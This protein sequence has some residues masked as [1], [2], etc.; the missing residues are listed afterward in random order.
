MKKLEQ[1]LEAS[2]QVRAEQ[3]ESKNTAERVGGVLCDLTDFLQNKT[4][5]TGIN[6]RTNANGVTIEV[7]AQTGDGQEASTALVFPKAS[8]TQA[9]I[10]T[11]ELLRTLRAGI[12][13]NSSSIQNLDTVLQ[14]CVS[15]IS[16]A[17]ASI[18]ENS[19]NIKDLLEASKLHDTRLANHGE[20][21]ENNQALLRQHRTDIAEAKAA[22][23]AAQESIQ[24]NANEIASAQTAISAAQASIQENR[25][26]IGTLHTASEVHDTRLAQ[27]GTAIENA[28]TSIRTNRTDIADAK[29]AI[30]AAQES[31]KGNANDI[32]DAKAAISA[33][34]ESIQENRDRIGTLHTAS[35]I[36]D[37]RLGNHGTAIEDAQKSILKHTNDIK[38]VKSKLDEYPSQFILD[39]GTV[40]SQEEGESR[41]ASSDVAGNRNISFIRFQTQGV[42]NLKTT[43]ILQYPNG[44]NYTAQ[45]K[46]VDKAQW[47][48][49]VTGATGVKGAAT[50]ATQWERT[51]PHYLG[52][53]AA[54]RKIQFKDYTQTVSR[55]VQLPLATASTAGLLSEADYQKIQWL[56]SERDRLSNAINDI[57]TRLRALENK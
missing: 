18:N 6:V 9:G 19:D 22:I 16:A 49:N 7:R 15:K 14:D 53:D 10:I 37:I 21:I 8:E 26:R 31:I 30:S 41:A 43:L 39:L 13:G 28:Q 29:A 51:A 35:E 2:A 50:T 25:Y 42:S 1:I 12:N 38:E 34:Q 23:S 40:S 11:S 48:R 20:A 57:D 45:I 17:Q 32:S 46:Y 33:A 56:I 27:H 55:D 24:G 54:T 5:L 4:A 36:H 47:R 3:Q 44:E 52:Y